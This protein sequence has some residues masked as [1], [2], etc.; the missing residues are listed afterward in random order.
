VIDVCF[1]FS[2]LK[3]ESNVKR[4]PGDILPGQ[5]MH[6]SVDAGTS[7]MVQAIESA[8]RK[9]GLEVHVQPNLLELSHSAEW[10]VIISSAP[11]VFLAAYAA[12]A[13]SDAW[14]ATKRGYGRLMQL[15]RDLKTANGGQGDGR[16]ELEDGG[17][18]WLLLRSDTP[19]EAFR[20]LDDVDWTIAQS[21]ALKWDE[22]R[23]CWMYFERGAEPRPVPKPQS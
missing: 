4:C 14:D 21:G 19:E 3:R 1:P 5:T 7:D 9:A 17:R 2:A 6:V 20:Q 11:T 15:V 8:F 10:V 12:K 18:A 13:G 16:I 22:H 23:Q